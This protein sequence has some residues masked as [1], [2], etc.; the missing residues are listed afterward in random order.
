[1]VSLENFRPRLKEL[2]LRN[3]APDLVCNAVWVLSLA[4][5][6]QHRDLRP[7]D[8]L[9][10]ILHLLSKALSQVKAFLQTLN[11][12]LGLCNAMPS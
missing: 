5:A 7:V 1:M 6:L 8:I 12:M 9:E 2:L 4:T 11:K 3:D 10:P